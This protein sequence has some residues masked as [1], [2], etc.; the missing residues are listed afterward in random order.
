M[1]CPQSLL[2]FSVFFAVWGLPRLPSPFFLSFFCGD[3]LSF[4]FLL[5][6]VVAVGVSFRFRYTY[7]PPL[8]S[9]SSLTSSGKDAVD[10]QHNDDNDDDDDGGL[11]IYKRIEV[12]KRRKRR[13]SRS[14]Y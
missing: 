10:H 12:M 1:A 14:L 13:E 5:F 8:P 9:S 2:L 6:V 7:L 11:P 4:L 3:L